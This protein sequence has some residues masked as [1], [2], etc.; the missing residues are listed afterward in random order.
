[1][2]TSADMETALVK[3]V[4]GRTVA[5][6]NVYAPR[7]WPSTRDL[8]PMIKVG[9]FTE[10]KES[11]GNNA[12]QFNT[13]T[14]IR[15]T[16][17]LSALP[18]PNDQGAV[19]A[20]IALGIWQREIERAVIN[21][22]ILWKAGLQEFVSVRSASKVAQEGSTHLGELTMD[23]GLKFYQGPED[24][25]PIESDQVAE[26]A[27]YG[28]LI[29]VA[30]PTGTYTPPFPYPVETAPREKGPDGRVEIGGKVIL[31]TS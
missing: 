29:N 30:D 8:Y 4:Q 11:L 16:C 15:L 20:Q 12:P 21:N 17:T 10:D 5:G 14:T 3:C 27:L 7:D 2:T 31:E 13:T 9:S 25:Y 24:F 26:I 1:M 28:D 23:F 22:P 19:D 6:Q 18:K